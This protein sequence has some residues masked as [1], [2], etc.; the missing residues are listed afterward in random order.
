MISCHIW[1]NIW[2]KSSCSGK[3]SNLGL[4]VFFLGE[5]KNTDQGTQKRGIHKKKSIIVDYKVLPHQRECGQ[6]THIVGKL[7]SSNIKWGLSQVAC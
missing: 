5:K 1:P 4:F 3:Y 7:V 6:G 2:K